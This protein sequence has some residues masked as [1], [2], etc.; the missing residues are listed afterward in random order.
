MMKFKRMLWFAAIAAGVLACRPAEPPPAGAGAQAEV[1][2]VKQVLDDWYTA[3]ERHDAA[4]IERPL[5]E[6]FVIFEDT[7]RYGRAELLKG[8]TEGFAAGVQTSARSQLETTVRGDVAWSSFRNHE[9]FTPTNGTPETLDFIETVVF[10]RDDGRWKMD[11]Y[12]AT[13]VNRPQ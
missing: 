6:T 11:R 13:R 7:T 12:H 8:I 1:A 3:I 4:G 10:V 2:A 5:T 9:V